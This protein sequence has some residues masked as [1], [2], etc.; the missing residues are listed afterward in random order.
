MARRWLI[1]D[2]TSNFLMVFPVR[3]G[4]DTPTT[5]SAAVNQLIG[6]LIPQKQQGHRQGEPRGNTD[7]SSGSAVDTDR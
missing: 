3:Q 6:Q 1:A 2:S 4:T 7:S 5:F